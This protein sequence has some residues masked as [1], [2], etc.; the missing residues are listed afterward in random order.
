M[1]TTIMSLKRVVR[2]GRG[3]VFVQATIGNSDV[4]SLSVYDDGEISFSRSPG[5]YSRREGEH[6][7]TMLALSK[8]L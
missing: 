6:Y 8:T 2:A 5:R 1:K 4:M 3:F 7:T